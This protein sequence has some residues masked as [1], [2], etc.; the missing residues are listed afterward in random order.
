MYEKVIDAVEKLRKAM[1]EE[2]VDPTMGLP[3]ELFILSTAI[4]PTVNV[5]LFITN[6]KHQLLLSW[7]N[8][9]YAGKGWHIPGGCVRLRETMASRIKKTAWAELGSE[10]KFDP[11][12]IVIREDI[13]SED[14]Y[15]LSNQLERSH[16]IS[17]LFKCELPDSYKISDESGEIKWFDSIPEDLLPQHRNLYGDILAHYFE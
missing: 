10:I 9:Q 5:D 2:G 7:R 11:E 15:W 6:K 8:D 12:P 1:E 3:E 14:R 16:N 17:F 4:V 13:I